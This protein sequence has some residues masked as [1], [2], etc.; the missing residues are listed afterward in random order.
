MDQYE[1]AWA[2]GFFDGEGWAGLTSQAGRRARQP[3]AQINQADVSGVPVVLRRF[4]I[5]VEG[6]G[7]I[8][9]PTKIEGRRDLYRWELSSQA[10][11]THLLEL[12]APWLGSRKLGQVALAARVR[13]PS[14]AMPTKDQVWW[15][16]AAGLY[17]GE[18]CSALLKHRTHEGYL[19][20]ELSVTQSSV[21]GPPEVLTRLLSIVGVGSIAGPYKQ[22]SASMDVYRWKASAH[23]DALFVINGLWPYL[24]AVKRMQAQRLV[25]TLAAQP[26]LP[27]G[28]PSWGNNKTH[29]VNGHDYAKARVRPFRSRKDGVEPRASSQCLE[30]LRDYARRKRDEKK[31]GDLGGIDGGAS[32]SE[33]AAAY[34]LK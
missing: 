22:R 5:A 8:H 29:C 32:V 23:A 24:G 2:A 26:V 25:D 10:G 12:L 15:A 9:G 3:H 11:A 19:T 20:P 16:W 4:Q 17:D 18:G 1:L 34:L 7:G 28:N 13:A 30:C 14:A 31:R 21:K 6:I 27:R 33:L